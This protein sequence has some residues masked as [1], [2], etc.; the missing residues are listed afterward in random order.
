MR[1]QRSTVEK[2][3]S[4]A[5]EYVESLINALTEKES[6][7]AQDIAAIKLAKSEYDALDE[8]NQAEL[9]TAFGGKAE[10]LPGGY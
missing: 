9:D 4:F 10:P 2:I 3:A 7:T 1:T 6:Y 8:E 5:V